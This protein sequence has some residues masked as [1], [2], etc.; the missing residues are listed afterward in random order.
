MFV[1]EFSYTRNGHL[2]ND[3]SSLPTKNGNQQPKSFA[4]QCHYNLL[5]EG[6]R[7]Y[8]KGS[9]TGDQKMT[10]EVTDKKRHLFLTWSSED[11]AHSVLLKSS[12]YCMGKIYKLCKNNSRQQQDSF[13]ASSAFTWY[14][15]LQLPC[16]A[17]PSQ[18]AW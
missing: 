17:K 6:I 5:V 13:E 11:V 15:A 7:F 1:R 8:R 4:Q 2:K 12:K 16:T 18:Y 14:R 3:P 10:S 9:T